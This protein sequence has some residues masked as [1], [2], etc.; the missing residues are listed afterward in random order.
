MTP[1]NCWD[2]F[3]VLWLSELIF[4]IS[5]FFHFWIVSLK[6][7]KALSL[8]IPSILCWSLF[9]EA[10]ESNIQSEKKM[11]GDESRSHLSEACLQL[12]MGS[13]LCLHWTAPI[14]LFSVKFNCQRVC[15]PSSPP[16]PVPS[17]PK[18]RL[19]SFLLWLSMWLSLW[20]LVYCISSSFII[21]NSDPLLN[22]PKTTIWSSHFMFINFS[23]FF[24]AYR[25]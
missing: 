15:P 4:P 18:S 6:Y 12:N 23:C 22:F 16:P 1:Y 17:T 24:I 21:P 14:W 5:K 8:K 19:L 7:K 25:I 11:K 20:L 3:E 9:K 13:I 10:M 2:I